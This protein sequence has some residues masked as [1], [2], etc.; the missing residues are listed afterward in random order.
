MFDE[1]K[2]QILENPASFDLE[3][4]FF[5]KVSDHITAVAQA[6]GT[7]KEYEIASIER[8]QPTF[9]A[10]RGTLAALLVAIS[11]QGVKT[12]DLGFAEG[13]LEA[14]ENHLE[15]LRTLLKLDQRISI[16]GT[17]REKI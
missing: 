8:P 6:D 16:S 13:K 11:A 1:F 7:L 15:D 2:V 9:K 5:H 10:S 12:K 17:P 14:T 4:Y 3:V